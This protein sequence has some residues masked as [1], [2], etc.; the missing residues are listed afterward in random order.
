M[1]HG[2]KAPL[3]TCS[4]VHPEQRRLPRVR[5]LTPWSSRSFNEATMPRR[6]MWTSAGMLLSGGIACRQLPL[7]QS[8]QKQVRVTR[9]EW[10]GENGSL[11]HPMMPLTSSQQ[12]N[13]LACVHERQ[14][15][16]RAVLSSTSQAA[17]WYKKTCMERGERGDFRPPLGGERRSGESSSRQQPRAYHIHVSTV[18]IPM[19]MVAITITRCCHRSSSA[20]RRAVRPSAQQ[21]TSRARAEPPAAAP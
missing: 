14:R 5:G 21:R 13:A 18:S 3:R 10:H 11:L 2:R 12:L 9:K 6:H 16:S 7:T 4:E 1:L 19:M 8:E 17:S 15:I 20:A